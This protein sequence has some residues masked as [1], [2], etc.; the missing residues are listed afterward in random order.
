MI[1]TLHH[2]ISCRGIINQYNS[3]SNNL[4][5]F[6]NNVLYLFGITVLYLFGILLFK[7]VDICELIGYKCY[8]ILI[9][10]CKMSTNILWQGIHSELK[11]A[12]KRPIVCNSKLPPSRYKHLPLDCQVPMALTVNDKYFW[13]LTTQRLAQRRLTDPWN[14]CEENMLHVLFS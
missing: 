4:S 9:S 7:V 11:G 12:S 3:T 14:S 10:F 6:W 1:C 5:K 8:W 13:T 2:S